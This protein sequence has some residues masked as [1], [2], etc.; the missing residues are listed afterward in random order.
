MA[1]SRGITEG[2]RPVAVWA[3]VTA[4]AAA[5]ALATP[6]AWASVGAATGP[7][8][9]A[10]VVVA[11]CATVLAVALAWLWV[12]TTATV[13]DLLRGT[14]RPGGG[15]TRRLVL[16]ACGAAVVAGT[17]VPAVASGGEGRELLVGLSLPERAVAPARPHHPPPPV[18]QPAAAAGDTYV[19]R[20][21]DSLW[22]IA[23]AHPVP[24]TD[25]DGRWR[26]IWAANRD[27]VGDDPDLI[28]PGQALR[29][30]GD[31]TDDHTDENRTGH[32]D[33]GGAR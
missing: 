14:P 12:V 26:S 11:G 15:A 4:A 17:T 23:R 30:P 3:V 24:G 31:H 8:G 19:V 25:I 18:A 29:L 27:L 6:D 7:E 16:V 28:L 33:E 13:A 1:V 21:G 2:W 9:I 20:T 10:D 5:S 22:S 32:D